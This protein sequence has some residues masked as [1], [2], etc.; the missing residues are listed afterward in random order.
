M[1]KFLHL[2]DV[3]LG[4][5]Q[6]NSAE[7][8]RDFF[9]AFK[10]SID[11]YALPNQVDFVLIAGD[12]FDNRNILPNTFSHAVIVLKSL[13]NANIPVFIIEGNHDNR[14]FSNT[15]NWLSVLNG[16]GL[17]KLLEPLTGQNSDE[18][19]NLAPWDEK[20]KKGSYYDYKN[21]RI[22]GARW[23]GSS[24]SRVIL[25]Y[26]SAIKKLPPID[27]S[28][29]MFHVGLEGFINE[30]AGGISYDD[31][32]PFKE[33]VN[34]LAI[35]HFHKKYELE[36]WIFNPGS[37][38]AC[39]V[40]EYD[41][42]RGLYR[43]TIEKGSH[44]VEHLTDYK[45]RPFIRLTFDVSHVNEPENLFNRIVDFLSKNKKS[46]E[47]KPVIELNLIGQLN[48]K[49]YELDIKQLEAKANEI[50]EPLVFLLKYNAVP[51][52]LPVAPE[53]IGCDRKEMETQILRDLIARDGRYR[54]HAQKWTTVVTDLKTMVLSARDTD[55]MFDFLD[56]NE[57][58]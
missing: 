21:I 38:E 4:Y 36:N 54:N 8:Q 7:R 49:R 14:S 43:V 35:G 1:I 45:Q 57:L 40:S 56:K 22:I 15:A 58:L 2:A 11:R 53:A 23:F 42:P 12:F 28:I 55:E 17:V 10:D 41:Y 39:S 9:H 29:L 18:L 6:Y 16:M 30:Y 5:N 32:L 3:H 19:F 51:K 47:M 52:D 26:V 48:F 31:I 50:L 24:T 13:A 44:A 20:E 27:Y 46:G 37:L 34:Y 33:V 25:P